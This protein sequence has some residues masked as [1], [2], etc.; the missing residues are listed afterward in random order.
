MAGGGGIVTSGYSTVL[1]PSVV[2][3]GDGGRE[4]RRWQSLRHDGLRLR[5]W[6][7]DTLGARYCSGRWLEWTI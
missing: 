1:F 5:H 4:Q 2:V 7:H 3:T 6:R